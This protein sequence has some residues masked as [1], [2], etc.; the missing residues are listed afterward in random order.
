MVPHP[1][2]CKAMIMQRKST[3]TGPIQA[4]RL[5]NNLIKWTTSERLLEVPVDI[6]LSWSDHD[7]NIATSFESKFSLLRRMRYLPQKQWQDFLTKVIFPSVTYG[8]TVWE[9][10]NKKHLSKLKKL[11]VRAGQN[12]HGLAWETSAEHVLL[13]TE[14]GSLETMNKA[15]LTEIGFKCLKDYSVAEFKNVFFQSNWEE[16]EE[17]RSSFF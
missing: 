13:R 9:S 16:A 5:G 2:K 10:C 17:G 12:E 3:L 14:W 8:L 1:W 6:S 4:L 15:R 11:H 7:P